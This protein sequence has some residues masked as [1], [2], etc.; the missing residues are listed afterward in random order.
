MAL[1]HN[2]GM[3]LLLIGYLHLQSVI[4]LRVFKVI[5]PFTVSPG[6][7]DPEELSSVITRDINSIL[8]HFT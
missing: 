7:Y 6:L 2:R 5:F 8:I 3:E 4:S 1:F